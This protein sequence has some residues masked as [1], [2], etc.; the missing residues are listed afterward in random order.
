MDQCIALL[1]QTLATPPS[2]TTLRVNSLKY[3]SQYIMDYIQDDVIKVMMTEI[4]RS[5]K[6]ALV[7]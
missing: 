3:S 5:F 4:V 7:L 2:H 6:A 1:K